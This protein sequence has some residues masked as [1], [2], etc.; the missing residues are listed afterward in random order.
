MRSYLVNKNFSTITTLNL[1][2]QI[3]PVATL[4][5]MLL[6]KC[7]LFEIIMETFIEITNMS[8]FIYI[9]FLLSIK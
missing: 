5:C 6:E 9:F 7:N 8:K 3:F 2:V 4:S 1:C